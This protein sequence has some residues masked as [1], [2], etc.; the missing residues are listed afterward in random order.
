MVGDALTDI[1][2]GLNAGLK[3]SIGVL[4]GFATAEQLRTLTP[5][6]VHDVSELNLLP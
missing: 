6:V 1:Q 4:S 3:A 5:F 2:M